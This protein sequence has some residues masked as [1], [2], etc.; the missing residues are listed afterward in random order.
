MSLYNILGVNSDASIEEIKS[1]YRKK[2]LEFHPDKGGNADK[3]K[4]I[5]EA[6]KILNDPTLRLKYDNYMRGDYYDG[7]RYNDYNSN[8]YS[9]RNDCDRFNVYNGNRYNRITKLT[10]GDMI[11]KIVDGFFDIAN[12]NSDCYTSD[13]PISNRYSDSPTSNRYSDSP[14]SNRYNDSPTSNRYNDSPTS[15]RYSDLPNSNRYSDPPISN[16]YSDL[17]IS[18]R[19]NDSSTSNRYSDPPISNRYSDP[20]TSNLYSDSPTSISRSPD[21]DY[22]D[23]GVTTEHYTPPLNKSRI[24]PSTNE[25]KKQNKSIPRQ[26]KIE[27]SL[28]VTLEE[29]YNCAQKVIRINRALICKQCKGNGG[30]QVDCPSCSDENNKNVKRNNNKMCTQCDMRGFIFDPPCRT[31]EGKQYVYKPSFVTISLSP[32]MDLSKPHE[33]YGVFDEIKDKDIGTVLA[34]QLNYQEHTTFKR[35]SNYDLMIDLKIPLSQAIGNLSRDI[36]FL[37]GKD[38]TLV[39]D[40][41]I[42]PG[43]ILLARGMG[44]VKRINNLKGNDFIVK[45]NNEDTKINST[46]SKINIGNGKVNNSDNECSKDSKDNKDR[47]NKDRE[48]KDRENK[49][50]ENK[51]R[52]NKDRE[53]KHRENKDKENK[54]KENKD[55]ENK[56]KE[57]KHKENKHRENKSNSSDKKNINDNKMEGIKSGNLLIKFD[58]E[59]PKS[60]SDALNNN[61]NPVLISTYKT[62]KL[63]PCS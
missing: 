16:K 39:Y 19:Y 14:T 38:Y 37:D 44:L 25:T 49:D 7:D 30:F 2:A 20:P 9:R 46:D 12:L 5:A 32:D 53:N 43:D 41:V 57:N 4:Q 45:L 63:E 62:I 28:N 34:L 22:E 29:I 24:H 33:I 3:F 11:S 35:H 18:N 26:N 55:R 50:R 40:G 52:E 13:V 56:G 1:C 51:D 8:R 15:N 61:D 36:I 47:E 31:C 42:K 60:V 23:I 6:Y 10:F 58:I 27:K 54:D 48:N 59:F 17:P 21:R